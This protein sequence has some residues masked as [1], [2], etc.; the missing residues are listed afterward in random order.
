MQELTERYP[1]LKEITFKNLSGLL[2]TLAIAVPSLYDYFR[3]THEYRWIALGLYFMIIFFIGV[4]EFAL[5]DSPLPASIY[6][7]IQTV[8]VVSILA[9][10]P[11]HEYV[12][13]L[14]FVLSAEA[15]TLLHGRSGYY[16]IAL[17]ALITVATLFVLAGAEAALYNSPIYI[18]GYLFFGVFSASAARA[19]LAQKESQILLQDLREAHEK[20]QAYTA[21]AE[22]LA[23]SEERNRLSR[24]MH[25]TLGHRLTVAIVQLEGAKR[26]VK[27]NPDKAEQIVGTVHE[28][29]RAALSELRSTVATL[30]EPL[31]SDI[32][33]KSALRALGENFQAATEIQV[34][35]AF[36]YKLP[37]FPDEYRVA[38]YRAAQEALTNVQR[39]A[40]ADKV[41]MTL[42]IVD[43]EINLSLRD[44][45]IGLPDHADKL[46]FGLRGIQERAAQLGGRMQLTPNPEGGAQICICLP[47]PE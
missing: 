27:E 44:N 25:D 28:Q 39:H 9:L 5:T 4:R 1:L 43:D 45:G 7:A 31:Q 30:R 12:I 10:P 13:I 3:S 32:S 17:F 26:L 23:V 29:M 22:E 15:T 42:G 21:Q 36:A 47:L 37:D 14:F 19:E 35:M 24:E 41:R 34:E 11:N 38:I 20:L 46:G 6:L 16:W 40:K 18:G 2:T 8:L 33:L